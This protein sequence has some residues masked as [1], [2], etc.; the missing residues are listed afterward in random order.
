MSP[1]EASTMGDP[2]AE[3]ETAAKRP[4]EPP[5]VF[6]RAIFLTTAALAIWA[7]FFAHRL[8][9]PSVLAAVLLLYFPAMSLVTPTDDIELAPDKTRFYIITAVVL[10]GLGGLGALSLAELRPLPPPY[11]GILGGIAW[12]SLLVQTSVLLGGCLLLMGLFHLLGRTLGWEERP[13]VRQLMPRTPG[14]GSTYALL[15]GAAGI[16]EE[17]AYRA[18]LP[19]YLMPWT[20]SYMVAAL[21]PCVAFGCLHMYQGGHGVFRTGLIGLLL[22]AGVSATGTIWAAVAA[23]TLLN[24]LVGLVLK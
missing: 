19:V 1:G 5:V 23:H 8:L 22:A 4:S 17:I 3:A 14:E 11:A 12:S 15:S 7:W 13:L 2:Q 21:I 10:L 9:F 20:E 18:F 24:L 6:A 16:G